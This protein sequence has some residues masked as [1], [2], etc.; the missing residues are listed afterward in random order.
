MSHEVFV[1]WKTLGRKMKSEEERNRPYIK[2][3]RQK[4][5]VYLYMIKNIARVKINLFL[6]CDI[7]IKI[8]LLSAQD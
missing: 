7:L 3:R 6:S 1:V 2:K 8:D 4:A 5:H